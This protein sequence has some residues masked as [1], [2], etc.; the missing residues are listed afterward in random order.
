MALGNSGSFEAGWFP[1]RDGGCLMAVDVPGLLEMTEGE[2]DELFRRSEAGE[3]P[4]GEAEGT[5]LLRPG[6]ELSGPAAKLIHFIAWQGK[7]FDREQGE[8]RNEILPFGLKAV[9][10]KVY[11][12]ASWLDG[13]ETIVLDYSKTSLAA[14]WIRDEIREVAPG[15]YLG[16][17]YWER[18]KVLHFALKF[19]A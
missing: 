16:L 6:T 2:L 19:P 12:Q 17:V 18:K 15:T 14:H 5:V 9:R 4:N 10:A 3:M 1:A 8:L 7:V 11:K 13:K